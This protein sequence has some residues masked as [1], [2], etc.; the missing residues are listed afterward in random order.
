M[1]DTGLEPVTP[2]LSSWCCGGDAARRSTRNRCK[3][4]VFN[5]R[6]GARLAWLRESLSGR[7]CRECAADSPCSRSR[8]EEDRSTASAPTIRC[9]FGDLA[10]NQALALPARSVLRPAPAGCRRS[11]TS[12]AIR[13]SASNDGV[14]AGAF[15]SSCVR[16][17]PEFSAC[18]GTRGR[19]RP[20]RWSVLGLGRGDFG[21]A[22]RKVALGPRRVHLGRA[23]SCLGERRISGYPA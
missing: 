21:F 13:I 16:T 20:H 11:L 4:V 18:R 10:S 22:G 2:S 8:G 6:G 23:R 12:P 19:P 9:G 5:G 14:R 3:R 1:G 7:L 15:K 17:F